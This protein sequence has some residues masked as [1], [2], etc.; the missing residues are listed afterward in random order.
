[1]LVIPSDAQGKKITGIFGDPVSHSLS[2]KMHNFAFDKLGI[3]DWIY[4][5]FHVKPKDLK[6][7]VEDIRKLNI[8]GVNVT[9][10]HKE[11]VLP[12]MNELSPEAKKIGA[13]NT[14][15][16]DNGK[17]TGDNT[18]GMGF[19]SSLKADGD[20]DPKGKRAI[21]WGAGGAAR[22]MAFSLLEAGVKSLSIANRTPERAKNLVADLSHKSVQWLK[23]E[24][25]AETLI[26]SDL[27]VSAAPE[28]MKDIK[29]QPTMFIY[30]VVYG[31]FT[32]VL[33]AAKMAGA[34]CL[35]GLGMLVRQGALSFS[36]WTGKEPPVSV[37]REVFDAKF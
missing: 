1:M 7:A 24:D 25:V 32:P 19:I 33:E 23:M 37:M 28:S 9:L 36:H 16:N 30:D 2:P 29:F 6:A 3:K 8:A 12:L 27:Y 11:A 26:V 15:I 34:R 22:A 21:L 31:E 17:L 20:F 35:G 18:D 5:P 4:L 13:V 14:I 10:P